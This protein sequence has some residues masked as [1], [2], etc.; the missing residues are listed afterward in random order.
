MS[1]PVIGTFG[2]PTS[3][4]HFIDG[5]WGLGRLTRSVQPLHGSAAPF[6]PLSSAERDQFMGLLTRISGTDG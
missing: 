4:V 2:H 3:D 1:H 6:A 5:S